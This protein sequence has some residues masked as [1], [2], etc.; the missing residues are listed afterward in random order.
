MSIFHSAIVSHCIILLKIILLAL[1]L[2]FEYDKHLFL[3]Q[4]LKRFADNP[5]MRM[6]PDDTGW[7]MFSAKDMSHLCLIVHTEF[8]GSITVVEERELEYSASVRERLSYSRIIIY[9]YTIFLLRLLA[10]ESDI[11][12]R[13]V[14]G[15]IF[16]LS[17]ALELRMGNE[18]R[19]LCCNH[20]TSEDAKVACRELGHSADGM[21]RNVSVQREHVN[22]S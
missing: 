1:H 7:T 8:G 6:S 2:L 3:R 15:D 22:I 19:S 4:V 17:G 12:I 14:Y 18:W 11:D 13:I 9:C 16:D 20:W 21:V 10:D 5:S